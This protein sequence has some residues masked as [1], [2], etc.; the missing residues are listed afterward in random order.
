MF[1]LDATR[2]VMCKQTGYTNLESQS[3]IFLEFYAALMQSRIT[4][5]DDCMFSANSAANQLALNRENIARNS[6]MLK[7][8]YGR[9]SCWLQAKNRKEC[10]SSV[11]LD[12][13]RTRFNSD[14]LTAAKIVTENDRYSW[15][16]L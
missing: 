15:N 14:G 6:N 4:P 16:S 11:S 1:T 9:K 5:N 10:A 3:V 12:Y 13:C 8:A 7:V 2:A